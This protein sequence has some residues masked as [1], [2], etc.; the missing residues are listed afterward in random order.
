M[1][2][3]PDILPEPPVPAD[4]D[5]RDFSFM[6]LDVLRLRDSDFAAIASGEEFKAAVLL[7]CAAWHQVPAGSLPDDDRW[8]ARHSG[9]GATWAGLKDAVLAGFVR[10]RD[11][12]LYHPVI[13]EKARE[14]G[15]RK[16]EQRERT[17]KARATLRHKREP[18]TEPVTDSA[19]KPATG[20]K[21]QGQGKRQRQGDG[22]GQGDS[23]PRSEACA[24]G[25]AAPRLFDEGV[26]WLRSVTGK[27]DARCR[28]LVGRWRKDLGDDAVLLGLID[29]ARASDVQ[30][31]ESWFPRAIE[32]RRGEAP[33]LTVESIL[34]ARD[35]DP[36]WQGVAC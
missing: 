18:V 30:A 4:L 32:R 16:V 7:W 9:T 20:A 29:E 11:G 15:R 2:T 23:V 8:L 35:R 31:P 24:S 3:D 14:A 10:C 27:P 17:A 28:A 36:A 26:A 25:A 1:A 34:A 6:P 13:V 22:E 21:R 33:R 5:L 12:R 19:C